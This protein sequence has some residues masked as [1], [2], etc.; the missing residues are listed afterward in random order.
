MIVILTATF[1]GFAYDDNSL[2]NEIKQIFKNYYVTN[3]PDTVFDKN[4]VSDI[5]KEINKSDPYTKYYSSRQYSEFVSTI[6]YNA[7]LLGI[8]ITMGLD[9]AK[10]ESV[11]KNSPEATAGIMVGDV[12]VMVDNHILV[13]MKQELALKYILGEEEKAVNLKIKRG[14]QFITI[15]VKRTPLKNSTVEGHILD[16]HIGYIK[17]SSFGEDTNYLFNY[18]LNQLQ[19][20]RVDS[21]IIDLRYNNGGFFTSALDIAGY[22]I[23]NSTALLTK[24]RI[25]G[26]KKYKGNFQ[27]QLIDRPTIFLINGFSASASEILAAAVKDYKKAW[28][29]GTRTHG[30]GSIQWPAKLSNGDVLKL[31]IEKFYSPLGKQIDKVGIMPDLNIPDNIDTMRFAQLILDTNT[32]IKST[33]GYVRINF[34]NKTVVLENERAITP[35]FWNSY[36]QLLE[37]AYKNGSVMIGNSN[38]VGWK[39]IQKSEIRDY[40]KMYYPDYKRVV[41][42]NDVEVDSQF[43]LKFNTNITK[44]SFNDKN[45]ELIDANSGKRVQFTLKI[46]NR[47]SLMVIPV[48]DLNYKET[49]YLIVHPNTLKTNKS[50]VA[51]GMINE[52]HTIDNKYSSEKTKTIYNN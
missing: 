17:I 46:A 7:S 2:L 51:N 26:E 44:D 50:S 6:N 14:A 49:Y 18:K 42:L 35:L 29:I 19:K 45:I 41:K 21:Y 1:S 15:I 8:Y 43:T 3:L 47:K 20:S 28:F 5:M 9:G 16:K 24:N 13:G 22:F 12:I 30:K 11:V 38:G 32:Y 40:V 33:R 31:T 27:G 48:N 4:S 52:I 39:T 34:N 37:L 36:K 25:S 10:I 23:G